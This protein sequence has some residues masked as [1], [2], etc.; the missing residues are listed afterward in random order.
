MK[1]DFTRCNNLNFKVKEEGVEKTGYNNPSSQD[2]VTTAR[3]IGKY[4]GFKA[5]AED[6]MK[7]DTKGMAKLNEEWKQ[8]LAIQKAMLIDKAVA[9][10]VDSGVFGHKDSYGA[11]AFK[12]AMEK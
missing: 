9:V 3:M 6:Q 7:I 11:K 10:L 12:Q 8:N 5:G 1:Y 2:I 4:E